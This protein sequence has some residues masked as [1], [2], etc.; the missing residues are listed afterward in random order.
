MSRLGARPKTLPAIVLTLI[1]SLIPGASAARA[2]DPPSPTVRLMAVGDI[3]LGWEVGRRIVR[4]GLDPF[5]YVE[6]YFDQANLVMGNLE[7]V[8]STSTYRWPKKTIH[9]RAPLA[10][11]DTLSMAGID[12]LNVANNHALDFGVSGFED[13]LARLDERQIG[14]VGGGGDYDAA[15]APLIVE[16]NGLRIAFLGYVLPFSGLTN[17]RTKMWAAH[18]DTP[19]LAMGKPDVVAADVTAARARA[20]VVIV[21]FHGGAEYRHHPNRQARLFATAAIDAGAALVVGHHPHV[22]QGYRSSGSSLIAYSMGNFVFSRFTG[23]SNDSAI[24]DVTLGAHGVEAFSWIPIVIVNG[25]PQPAGGA[26]AR[27]IMGEIPS[28]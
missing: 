3:S 16:V 24:L 8:I 12:V 7:C 28:L 13:T 20:D 23:R 1:V 14:Y 19:G 25:V 17:F 18:A 27:R 9:L 15:H 2:E 22:L 26:D 5:R 4:H 11:A 6:T 21:T 10:A